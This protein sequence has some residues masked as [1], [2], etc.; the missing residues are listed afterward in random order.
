[1]ELLEKYLQAVKF[2][3]PSSQQ[4]D[5]IA[6][7]RD[8]IRSEVEERENTLGRNLDEKELEA[9]LKQR[10]RPLLVAEK[11]LPQRWL[12]GPVLFPAYW[13]VLRLALLCYLLPCILVWSGILIFSSSYRAHHLGL[14]AIND[15]SFLFWNVPFVFTV[16]TLI[17]IGVDQAKDKTWLERDWSPSKLPAVRDTQRIPRSGSGIEIMANLI[18]GLWWLKIL[19]TLTAF[20]MGG[21]GMTIPPAWHKYFWIFLPIWVY[22]TSLSAFNL[23]RPYWTRQRRGMKAALNYLTAGALFLVAK[24]VAALISDWPSI[25][26]GHRATPSQFLAFGLALS[27]GIAALICFIIASTDTWQA[28]RSGPATP[29]LNHRIAV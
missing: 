26:T 7:L 5:I 18:F 29:Q 2:W 24:D 12:I 23:A 4:N 10:G 13:F 14:A 8:D 3:L 15:L 22:S 1:M 20:N 19:W 27:F 28:L 9:L 25:V 16:V 17:F 11:Y 21:I 6:E